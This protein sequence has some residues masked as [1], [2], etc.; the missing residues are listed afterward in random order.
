MLRLQE[1]PGI[2]NTRHFWLE[3]FGAGRSNHD[4]SFLSD[5]NVAAAHRLTT[6]LIAAS[7]LDEYKEA[8]SAPPPVVHDRQ[9]TTSDSTVDGRRTRLTLGTDT[10]PDLLRF[11]Q[12][13]AAAYGIEP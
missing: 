12:Q 10:P 11:M 6:L 5:A 3:V 2:P 8:R 9:V 4:G 13:V 1:S 7:W